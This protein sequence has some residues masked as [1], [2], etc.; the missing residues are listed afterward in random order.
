MTVAAQRVGVGKRTVHSWLADGKVV[1][2]EPAGPLDSWD[3]EEWLDNAEHRA[4]VTKVSP[5]RPLGS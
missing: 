5:V 3:T 1:R 4:V 2:R